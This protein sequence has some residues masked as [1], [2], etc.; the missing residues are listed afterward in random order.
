VACPDLEIGPANQPI[1]Y[2]RTVVAFRSPSTEI[3]ADQSSDASTLSPNCALFLNIK[4]AP[5]G[6]ECPVDRNS[7]NVSHSTRVATL[8]SY[9]TTPNDVF[10]NSARGSSCKTPS[11]NRALTGQEYRNEIYFKTRIL[12]LS[13]LSLARLLSPRIRLQRSREFFLP[14]S[15]SFSSPRENLH[16]ISRAIAH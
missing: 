10:S 13:C 8:N 9:R 6:G 16:R 2:P 15:L 4:P 11:V 5:A 7:R 14:L 1:T 3:S 12:F